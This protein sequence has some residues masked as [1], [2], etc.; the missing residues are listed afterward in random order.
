MGTIVAIPVTKLRADGTIQ[1]QKKTY[2]SLI[3]GRIEEVVYGQNISQTLCI[4][5]YPAFYA[6]A[7]ENENLEIVPLDMSEVPNVV[8]TDRVTS[9]ISYLSH[10]IVSV[11]ISPKAAINR[12]ELLPDDKNLLIAYDT[13][14]KVADAKP[15]ADIDD[16]QITPSYSGTFTNRVRNIVRAIMKSW[17]DKGYIED[18][19]DLKGKNNAIKVLKITVPPLSH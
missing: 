18:W 6:Y 5:D 13:I 19:E 2:L 10:L 15:L 16:D 1:Y 12:R 17:K 3:P 11:T 14:Y 7:A 4:T 9:I 8:R